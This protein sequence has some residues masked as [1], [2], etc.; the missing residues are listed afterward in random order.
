MLWENKKGVLDTSW[1]RAED[2][3]ELVSVRATRGGQVPRRPPA[4]LAP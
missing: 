2:F 1:K 4:A 3:V